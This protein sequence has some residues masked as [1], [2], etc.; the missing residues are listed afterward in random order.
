MKNSSEAL[1]VQIPEPDFQTISLSI[2]NIIGSAMIMNR[3]SEL[4]GEKIKKTQL[5]IPIKKTAKDPKADFE[6]SQYR[7]LD[8]KLGVPAIAIKAAMVRAA[9]VAGEN[10]TDMRK[11]FHVIGDVLP[12]VKHSTPIHREDFIPLPTGGRDWKNRCEIK[13]WTLKVPI[14]FNSNFISADQLT[15]LLSLAGFHCGLMDNRPN[16]PKC[17]GNHGMFALVR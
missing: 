8:G 4:A 12:F 7:T 2:K 5:K 10:M 1:K 3:F 13:D 14:T 15:N 11:G 9:K 6:A 17:S 16:S